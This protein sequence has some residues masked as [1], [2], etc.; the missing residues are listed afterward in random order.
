MHKNNNNNNNKFSNKNLKK[1]QEFKIDRTKSIHSLFILLS[2]GTKYI[3]VWA[4]I[5]FC[6]FSMFSCIL[7]WVTMSYHPNS[8]EKLPF[9]FF[10]KRWY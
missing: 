4:G 2:N 7:E 6:L 5:D 10:I 8:I 9:S 3:N 1:N